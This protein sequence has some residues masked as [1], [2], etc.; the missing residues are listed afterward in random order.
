MSRSKGINVNYMKYV[1]LKPCRP[2]PIAAE[3]VWTLKMKFRDLFNRTNCPYW[4]NRQVSFT[5][6]N[7]PILLAHPQDFHPF[8]ESMLESI[9]YTTVILIFPKSLYDIIYLAV[10]LTIDISPSLKYWDREIFGIISDDRMRLK[11]YEDG[12]EIAKHL[13]ASYVEV[14][15]KVIRRYSTR[16]QVFTLEPEINSRMC[17]PFNPNLNTKIQWF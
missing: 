2:F 8:W 3:N 1:I 17:A 10:L 6:S 15:Y 12:S 9:E 7:L 4:L 11:L 16:G 13:S 5:T 14:S